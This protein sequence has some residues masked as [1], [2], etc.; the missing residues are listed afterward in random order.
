MLTNVKLAVGEFL[1]SFEQTTIK[2]INQLSFVIS[3]HCT[4]IMHAAQ[5]R[6]C[7]AIAVHWENT[8]KRDKFKEL[9]QSNK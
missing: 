1:S 6:M 3:V 9:L 5:L 4:S 7:H 8:Q 2:C